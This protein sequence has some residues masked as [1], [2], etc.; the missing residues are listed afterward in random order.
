MRALGIVALLVVG[1]L[2]WTVRAEDE[3]RTANEARR[4]RVFA[5]IG[6]VT[7]TVGDLEDQINGR[8][9]YLRE[10]F[11]DPKILRGYADDR[12]RDAILQEG[13]ERLGYANDREV[14][15]FL[16]RTMAQLFVRRE[17]EGGEKLESITDEEVAQYYNDHSEDFRKPEMRRASHVVVAS[18]D[19]AEDIIEEL[20]KAKRKAVGS[21]A[22]ER[23]LDKETRLRGGDLLYFT[24]DGQTVGGSEEASIDP[25]LVAATFALEAR[26]DVTAAP[27]RLG[28]AKWSVLQ[29]TSIRP[30]RVESLEDATVG[31]RRKL[32]RDSRKRSLEAL[33]VKLREELQPQTF[34]ERMEAI[35][36]IPPGGPVDAPSP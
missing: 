26:G 24:E 2:S 9:P 14:V 34:P 29:L 1:A 15:T 36:L 28:D 32:W 35:V 3:A 11:A 12:V 13:A 23:S 7:I 8:S 21:I 20:G 6:D 31:I 10:R 19:E 27:I 22:K 25:A 5:T 16:D 17:I 18:E 30:A 33:L 4:A